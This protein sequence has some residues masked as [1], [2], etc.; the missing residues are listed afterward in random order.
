MIV[1]V[2]VVAL[3][4]GLFPRWPRVGQVLPAVRPKAELRVGEEALGKD[5]CASALHANAKASS[6]AHGQKPA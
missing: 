2:M 6:G 5:P 4:L 3:M 1:T